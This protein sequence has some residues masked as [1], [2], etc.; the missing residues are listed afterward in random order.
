V[1]LPDD[2]LCEGAMAQYATCEV[3]RQE[4]IM[5]TWKV[6]ASTCWLKFLASAS[7]HLEMQHNYCKTDLEIWEQAIRLIQS[8]GSGTIDTVLEVSK[9]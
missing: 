9:R 7:K 6:E 4:L 1:D 5:V 2:M 3:A 8:C